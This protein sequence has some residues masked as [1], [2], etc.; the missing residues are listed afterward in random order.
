MRENLT[1]GSM[2]G[3]WKRGRRAAGIT[4]QEAAPGGRLP[5]RLSYR[6]SRL[7]HRKGKG[8]RTFPLLR[9]LEDR[10]L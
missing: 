1:S 7:L 10:T 8:R 4:H 3:G 2:R 5:V 9:L 6:A